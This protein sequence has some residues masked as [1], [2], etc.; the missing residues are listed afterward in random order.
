MDSEKHIDYFTGMSGS[1]AAFPALLADAMMKDAVARGV[2][3]DLARR[4]AQQVLIAAGRLQEHNGLSP[5][6][7]VRSFVDYKGTTAAAIVAMRKNGFDDA[8]AAGLQAAF[9]TA[10]TLQEANFRWKRK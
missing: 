10:Q 8:V 6:E 1:G 5:S 3:E 9:Q 4:A 7:T 2:P